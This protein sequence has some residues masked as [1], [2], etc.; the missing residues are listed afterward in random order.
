MAEANMTMISRAEVNSIIT[1]ETGRKALVLDGT[2]IELGDTGLRDLSG[3]FVPGNVASGRLMVRRVGNMVT[4]LLNPITL[5]GEVATVW[6]L[7]S[8]PLVL[9]G[10]GS[11][12]TQAVPLM[13]SE[14]EHARLLASRNAVEIHYGIAGV[15][16]RGTLSYLTTETWPASLPGV[17]DG[18]PVGV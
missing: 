9:R 12:Y 16:Y 1:P 8:D 10:F 15:G 14:S 6:N 13:Q 11:E 2:T 4:W 17:A 5:A 7:I 18:Q 3:L